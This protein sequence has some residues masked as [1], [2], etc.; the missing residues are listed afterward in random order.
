MA[1]KRNEGQG[2]VAETGILDAVEREGGGPARLRHHADLL[3]RLRRSSRL[4]AGSDV[5]KIVESAA[6]DL[7]ELRE[8]APSELVR[9]VTSGIAAL[10][11]LSM[12]SEPA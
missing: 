1:G 10:R 12:I 4:R 9:R 7:E 3:H 2:F 6:T 8:G 11:C 5:G